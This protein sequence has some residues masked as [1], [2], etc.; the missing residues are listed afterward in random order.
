MLLGPLKIMKFDLGKRARVVA[1]I[2]AF[3]V[4]IIA[5][6]LGAVSSMGTSVAQGIVSEVE[7]A[8]KYLMNVPAIFGNN[9]MHC[10]IMFTPIL[11]PPYALYVLYST[12]RILAAFAVVHGINPIALFGFTFLFPHAWLEYAAYALA[13]SQSI[14]LIVGTVQ[15]RFKSEGINTCIL[16]TVCAL[17]LLLAAAVEITILPK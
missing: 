10:L 11:G 3:I 17:L 1:L 15:R 12:G 6:F 8:T 4:S 2:V 9:F 14:L 5:T 7:E 16:I 13:I